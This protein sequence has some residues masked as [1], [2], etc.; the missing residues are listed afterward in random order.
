MHTWALQRLARVATTSLSGELSGLCSPALAPRTLH[1]MGARWRVRV[2]S[3]Q[4]WA[5]LKPLLVRLGRGFTTLSGTLGKLALCLHEGL[6][7]AAA[8]EAD[9]AALAAVLRALCVLAGVAPYPRL[10]PGL[11]P[12]LLMVRST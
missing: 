2:R 3:C 9:P 1:C 5:L 10:P 7:Q 11:L 6:L 4:E 12:R 8:S